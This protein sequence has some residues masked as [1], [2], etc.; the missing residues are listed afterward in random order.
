VLTGVVTVPVASRQVQG[1]ALPEA[2]VRIIDPKTGQ[3]VATTTTD[4]DGKYS[5]EVPPGGPY[6]VEASKGNLKVLDVSPV[7]EA[8]KSYDLGTADATST[9]VALILQAR[10]RRGEDP[11]AINLDAIPGTPGFGNLVNAVTNALEA[12]QDPTQVPAVTNLVNTIVS[13]PAAPTGPT[14]PTAPTTSRV[15][16]NGEGARYVCGGGCQYPNDG[17]IDRFGGLNEISIENGRP[18]KSVRIF[19]VRGTLPQKLRVVLEGRRWRV[20]LGDHI[21]YAALGLERGDNSWSKTPQ[22]IIEGTLTPGGSL[23]QNGYKLTYKDGEFRISL[24][25][26]YSEAFKAVP[27]KGVVLTVYDEAGVEIG[28]YSFKETRIGVGP[29]ASVDE[30]GGIFPRVESAFGQCV[31]W[32]LWRKWEEEWK[33][34]RNA[35]IKSP[36]FY[37]PGKYPIVEEQEIRARVWQPLPHDII[38]LY[39]GPGNGHYAFVEKVEDFYRSDGVH[40][41]KLCISEFNLKKGPDGCYQIYS[42]NVIYWR[43]D[44]DKV[45]F[46]L[47]TEG[48]PNYYLGVNPDI[49]KDWKWY[50]VGPPRPPVGAG[51]VHNLTQNK[52]YATIQAA[53]DDARNGDEIVVSPGTYYENIDFQGKNITLRSENP[54]D[55]SVVASTT[56]DGNGLAPVVVLENVPG[57]PRLAG[58]T[59]INSRTPVFFKAGGGV[60]VVSSSPTIENNVIRGVEASGGGAIYLENCP[61]SLI[62]G[63]TISDNVLPG[64]VGIYAVSSSLTIEDNVI[65]NN[66]GGGVELH[67]HPLPPILHITIQGNE[68]KNNA[69]KGGLIIPLPEDNASTAVIRRNRVTRNRGLWGA[70]FHGGSSFVIEKNVFSNNIGESGGGVVL[71]YTTFTFVDN[72]VKNNS[73]GSHGGGITVDSYYGGEIGYNTIEGNNAPWLGGGILVGRFRGDPSEDLVIHDNTIVRNTARDGG[74]IWIGEEGTAVV[75]GN[76]ILGN[77]AIQLGGGIF[78]GRYGSVRDV[79]GS[80]WPRENC[81]PTGTET[82]GVWIYQNNTFSGNTNWNGSESEGC[83]VYFEPET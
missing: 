30:V 2:T 36:D 76:A 48:T 10:V 6:I 61:S 8:G 50:Y 32:A 59:I 64:S 26:D 54:D 57:N 33:P 83:H 72:E 37:C 56:I 49:Y 23:T 70:W 77:S 40:Y 29:C 41:K 53:I 55:P 9:A 3:V 44:R 27:W 47:N 66:A 13:P 74:G 4:R 63:N 62:R 42:S 15:E 80:L 60:H 28:K 20:D 22:T 12:G 68:I 7:V 58:F 14:G 71:D 65:Q 1:Q 82:N 69:G 35:M 52:Y 81:P 45:A 79:V 67:C 31:W 46:T 43:P 78:I 34:N 17:Y 39:R 75:Y 16:L 19:P 24:A 51:P 38:V 25:D 21:D 18:G 11:A 73:S 5:V